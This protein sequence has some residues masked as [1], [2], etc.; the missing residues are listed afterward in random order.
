MSRD[1]NPTFWKVIAE[2]QR[3]TGIPANQ[4]GFAPTDAFGRV[5]GLENVYAVGDMT[6][7]PIKHGGLATQQGDRVAHAIAGRLGFATKELRSGSVLHLRI[8]GGEQPLFLRAELDQFGQATGASLEYGDAEALG[9][10]NKVFGRY[11]VPYLQQLA[12]RM[13]AA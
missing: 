9:P 3:I 1:T 6:A 10:S 8:V 11:L 12:P 5:Q 2:F 4:F 7:Y 13:S